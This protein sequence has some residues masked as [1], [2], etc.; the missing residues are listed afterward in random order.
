MDPKSQVRLIKK[1]YAGIFAL[2]CSLGLL[3]ALPESNGLLIKDYR[4]HLNNKFNKRSRL[5]TQFIIIHTSEAGLASTLRTLS[6]GKRIGSSRTK[7]GHSHYAIA[8]DGRVFRTLWHQFRA[9]H[10][11]LSMWNGLQDISS[12]SLGIELVG[13]HYGEITSKQYDSVR[14][15]LKLLQRI[16]RIPDKNVLTHCQVA[17]GKPNLWFRRPH[18]GRKR[19]ARNFNRFKAGLTNGWAYD[20]DVRTKRLT[21][22]PQIHHLFYGAQSKRKIKSVIKPTNRLLAN[23]PQRQQPLEKEKL[24]NIIATNNTAW[25]IAG[26][27][28]NN[29]TTVYLFPDGSMLRGDWI[30]TQKGWGNLPSGTQ[31]LINQPLERE[32]K[33]GPIFK[34][35]GAYTAW[36]FAG[37]SYQK[38]STYYFFPNGKLVSGNHIRDWD[39]IPDNTCLIIG[40]NAPVIIGSKQGETP[41]SIAGSAYNKKTT[42]YYIPQKGVLG[43][44]QVKDFNHLPWGSQIFLPMKQLGLK[45]K[46]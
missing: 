26:E 5:S 23:Q 9:D 44:D 7:G 22:D 20:P 46:S 32:K 12:H 36:S 31:V 21:K 39:S 25:T 4:S 24:S 6:K 27:D 29:S 35:N 41:W 43:G 33:R 34:I 15:L 8:R 13:F 17:Y 40:Y 11:G 3:G 19:C 18:R 10:T 14:K 2:L 38:P 30:K 16:Y 37:A 28:Y 45:L 42:I 1:F